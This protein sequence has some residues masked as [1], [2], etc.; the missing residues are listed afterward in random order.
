[1]PDIAITT[2]FIVGFPGETEEDFQQTLSL[3]QAAGLDGAFVFKYSPRPGTLSADEVDDVPEAVKEER[4]AR[5]LEAA[6]AL[7]A[8]KIPAY[9]GTREEAL[10]ESAEDGRASGRLRKSRKVFFDAPG[11]QP[12]DLVTVEITGA[13]RR[14]L[15][16]KLA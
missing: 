12:G 2:D 1:M 16:G 10:V 5:L 7:S 15:Q 14:S 11:V 9:I 4:H 3:A 8:G 6:E 13:A